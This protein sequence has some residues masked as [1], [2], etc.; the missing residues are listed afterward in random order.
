MRLNGHSAGVLDICFDDRNI[1]SCSK[2][3]T[4]KVWNVITGELKRTLHGHLGPVNAVQL[5]DSRIISASGDALIKLWDLNTGE[6]IR[7]FVG[8]TRGL[9]CVQFDGRWVVSGSND[10]T[11]K[12]WDVETAQCIRTLK[13]HTDLVRTLHFDE[14]K[15]VSGSYDQ[16][17]KVWDLKTGKQLLDFHEGHTSWVFDVQ[18]NRTRIVSTNSESE[19]S[20][21]DCEND[22]ID[23]NNS[24]ENNNNYNGNNN[25]DIKHKYSTQTKQAYREK[26]AVDPSYVP[27]FGDFWFIKIVNIKESSSL[28]IQ[29]IINVKHT[30]IIISNRN[31]GWGLKNPSTEGQ[32][33]S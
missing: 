18:F 26:L 21:S 30:V 9:A 27:R 32:W 14:N 33:G 8:H 22:E 5:K 24:I 16:T 31:K 19:N 2:D 11:I 17:V 6:C 25:E 23:S 7:D 3:S 20:Q 12:I 10:R 28:L 29:N 15:I 4:I 13:G 1:V